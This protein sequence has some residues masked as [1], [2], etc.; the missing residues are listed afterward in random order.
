MTPDGEPPKKKQRTGLL[1]S[2]AK[3]INLPQNDGK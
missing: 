1:A 3:G 2:M